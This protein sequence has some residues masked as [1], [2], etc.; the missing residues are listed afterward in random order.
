MGSTKV[1]RTDWP[2]VWTKNPGN[3]SILKL[4]MLT[5]VTTLTNFAAIAS[6]RTSASSSKR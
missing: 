6:P 4:F 2:V 1:K 5:L 3:L